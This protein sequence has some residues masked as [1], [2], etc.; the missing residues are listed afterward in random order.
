MLAKQIGNVTIHWKE[1][2]IIIVIAFAIEC[3]I[4]LILLTYRQKKVVKSFQNGCYGEVIVVGKKLLKLYQKSA[5]IHKH[6]NTEAGMEYLNFVMAVSYFSVKDYEQFLYHIHALTQKDD[7]KEF[8][9]SLYYLRQNDFDSA[10]SHYANIEEND[11]T[12]LNRTYLES[13]KH[14]AQGE[15]DLAKTKMMEI[16]TD[17]TFPVLK[18]IADEVLK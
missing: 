13:M 3:L 16:Y 2:L 18:Q 11:E 5:K 6:R 4:L 14:Y 17:L 15:Y 12:Q 7:I 10:Q 1:P 8:W 9:L